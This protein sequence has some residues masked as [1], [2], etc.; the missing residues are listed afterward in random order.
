MLV[1]PYLCC[2]YSA[3]NLPLPLCSSDWGGSA[4]SSVALIAGL[5]TT[6][7]DHHVRFPPLAI[8]HRFDSFPLHKLTR[9]RQAARSG[10]VRL[11]SSCLTRATRPT[12][13]LRSPCSSRNPAR[14]LLR[15][16][17]G[18]T[19]GVKSAESSPYAGAVLVLISAVLFSLMGAA[20][21]SLSHIP[22]SQISLINLMVTFVGTGLCRHLLKQEDPD[23][24]SAMKLIPES[25]EL[26]RWM[27]ARGIAGAGCW[28]IITYG[29]TQLPLGDA[30]AIFFTLPCFTVLLSF[31]FLR[32]C[33]TET[34]VSMCLAY[35]R[36]CE[37]H[38]S[39]PSSVVY[40]TVCLL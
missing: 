24:S 26:R 12:G 4:P 25:P 34:P 8:Q 17:G 28:V 29:V 21:A 22:S 40:K 32:R 14:E 6:G 38:W 3:L 35:P 5:G 13:K 9:G 20:V 30:T 18:A 27:L 15:M 10:I 11:S 23:S 31:I 19:S 7:T 1:T 37:L 2:N 39:S 36:I 33:L 16:A